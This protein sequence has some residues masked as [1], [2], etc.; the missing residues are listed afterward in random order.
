MTKK[1]HVA[2][3]IALAA[4]F[5]GVFLLARPAADGSILG[6]VRELLHERNAIAHS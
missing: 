3:Q 2:F 4:M 6:A 5:L 1:K